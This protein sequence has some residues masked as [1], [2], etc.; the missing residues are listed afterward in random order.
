MLS[1]EGY[2]MFYGKME[3]VPK[4]SSIPPSVV[5]GTWLYKPEY[6]CWYCKGWSYPEEICQVV[7]DKTSPQD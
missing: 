6:K 4:T 3:I 7:E 5:E 1:V 2:K